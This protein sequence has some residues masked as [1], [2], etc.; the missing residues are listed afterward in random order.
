MRGWMFLDVPVIAGCYLPLIEK[1]ATLGKVQVARHGPADC[2]DHTQQRTV[3]LDS[4]SV[5]RKDRSISGRTIL[6]PPD[7]QTFSA[8][9]K[10]SNLNHTDSK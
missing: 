10:V 8:Q 6:F 5:T 3:W 7:S 2:F 9:T 1:A 4:E